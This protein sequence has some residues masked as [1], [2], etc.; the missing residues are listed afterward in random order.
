MKTTSKERYSGLIKPFIALIDIILILL[1]AKN[2]LF[3]ATNNKLS[4]LGLVVLIWFSSAL[5]SHFYEV[6]R[7]TKPIKILSLLIKQISLFGV[8]IFAMSGYLKNLQLSTN[9]ILD[10]LRIVFISVSFVKISVYYFLKKYRKYYNGNYRNVVVL[11][12]NKQSKTLETFFNTQLEYGFKH[13]K[14]FSVKEKEDI[15]LCFEYVLQNDVNEIY[16][17]ISSLSDKEILDVISFADNNLITL[18]FMPD[19]KNVIFRNFKYE[20]YNYIPILSLR[21][22]PLDDS[23]NKL[24][25]RLF[26]IIFS[27]L[28]I[29]FVLSWLTPIIALLIK[30]E[31]KGPIFFS[32]SR[33]GI[34]NKQFFCYK[35]R[36]MT[37]NKE[38]NTIQAT[39]NDKRVTKIGKFIRK[40][41]ID[42]LPQFFNVFLGNMSV[43]GP[44]PHMVSHTNKYAKSVDKFMVRH[45]VKP[46]I[47]GLAQVSGFRGEIESKADIINRVKYDIFYIEN[48][49]LLLDFKIIFLTINNVFKGEEKAY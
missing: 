36:S 12:N 45:F 13:L 41:S 21:N 27:L 10:F 48:W 7:I 17:S 3:T 28:V 29:L 18:K 44:R 26:D 46:G 20:Y 30:L 1:A 2:I 38:S 19:T 34:N 40:T 22:I 47:T 42:E 39:K 9:T 35:F 33:T 5:F 31:S 11:G 23:L 8:F 37:V 4:Y 49:S 6:Y 25:K 14:T 16:C 15:K 32:Q 24:V 43:V